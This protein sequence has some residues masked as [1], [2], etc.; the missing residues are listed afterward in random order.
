MLAYANVENKKTVH[1]K[2]HDIYKVKPTAK[3]KVVYKSIKNLLDSNLITLEE[4]QKL[5]KEYKS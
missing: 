3:D 1:A 2:M 5:W 4:A